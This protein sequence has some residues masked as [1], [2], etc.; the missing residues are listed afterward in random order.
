MENLTNKDPFLKDKKLVVAFSGGIDSVVLLHYLYVHYADNLRAIH[1]NH[2]LSKHCDEWSKFCQD[3]CKNLNIKYKNIDIFV[4]NTVN[5]EENGRKKRY[6]ALSINLKKDEILC[7]AHHK[8]DQAETLLL[9]LFRG[10][11]V[12]GLAAM[13]H[14]KLLEDGIHYRPFL[15]IEKSAIVD[16]ASKNNLSWIEDDNNTN[17]HFRRNFLRLKIIPKLSTVYQNLTKTLARVAKHQAEALQLTQA[18]AVIDIKNQRLDN[19]NNQLNIP[20]LVELE[21]YRLKNVLRYWLNSLNFTPPSD[22]I[23]QQIIAL[24]SAKK[25]SEPLVSWHQYKIRRYQNALYFIDNHAP[26]EENCP[27][28]AELRKLPN[29][30]IRYRTE[31]QRVKLAGKKHSQSLKKILQAAGIPPWERAGLK[32]Y[33]IDNELRAM[34]RIG[35]MQHADKTNKD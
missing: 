27:F 28:H 15:N 33:Y 17:T 30:S 13:P 5:I 3:F 6:H 1:C 10:S 19:G 29:F 2:H 14:T 11:G 26:I 22:K 4:E 12:A 20:R 25:D 35:R 32:M 7:T 18:L 34:E 21:T 9:Q 8:N 31:G 23:M 16:Y 24:L